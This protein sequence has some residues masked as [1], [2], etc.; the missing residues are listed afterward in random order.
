MNRILYQ[1]GYKCEKYP[2]CPIIICDECLNK[3]NSIRESNDKH[4]HPLL[5]VVKEDYTCNKCN[6]SSRYNY[7]FYCDKCNYGICFQCYLSNNQ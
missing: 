3:I 1:E 4:I 2:Q 5:L 6:N 7:Y